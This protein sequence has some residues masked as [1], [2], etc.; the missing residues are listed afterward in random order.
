M[1][2]QK[3]EDHIRE[4]IIKQYPL[5]RKRGIRKDEPLLEN[6]ILDSIGIL[7]LVGYLE[8]EFGIVVDDE[9]LVPDNFQTIERL[10]NFVSQKRNGQR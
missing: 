6:G 10:V 4:C 8:E 2:S 3:I 1:D 9:D 7:D 5:V